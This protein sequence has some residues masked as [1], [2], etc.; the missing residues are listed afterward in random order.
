MQKASTTNSRGSF[1]VRLFVFIGMI[2][3]ATVILHVYTM[4]ESSAES[5]GS[6]GIGQVINT[7]ILT[8]PQSSTESSSF[9]ETRILAETQ[10]SPYPPS[11]TSL[12]QQ[13]IEIE[14]SRGI[15]MRLVSAGEFGMGGTVDAALTECQKLYIGGACEPN[16]FSDEVPAHIVFLDAFYMDKYEVSIKSYR[17][18]IDDGGCEPPMNANSNARSGYYDN[19]Q[20]D[21]YPVI[22]VDWY[23]ATAYCEW[24]GARLPTE[25]EWEKAARGTDGRIYP[26]G[27]AFD[28]VNTNF[29]DSNCSKDGANRE[30]D[31]GYADTAPVDYYTDGVSVYGIFNLAGNVWEW[32]SDWYGETYYASSLANNPSGPSSGGARVVRGGSWNDFGDVVRTLNR[33]WV[34]AAFANDALGFRCAR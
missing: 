19:P 34:R 9:T 1:R 21:N 26:W 24:R 27:N 30:F 3:L 15:L 22:N 14:D 4:D 11:P 31:D 2:V 33:N 10:T 20:F 6:M 28:G 25:A 12:H 17:V 5:A 16:W 13:G 18:C 8:A 23:M 32:V 7:P 29:C